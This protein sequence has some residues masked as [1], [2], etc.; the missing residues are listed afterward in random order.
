MPEDSKHELVLLLLRVDAAIF[1]IRICQHFTQQII[2]SNI[3]ESIL[4]ALCNP[5]ACSND[6]YIC[7]SK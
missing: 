3:I 2:H 5:I 6:V 7:M 4:E 1:A